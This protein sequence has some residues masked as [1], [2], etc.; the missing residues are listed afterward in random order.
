[1]EEWK[2]N[3]WRNSYWKKEEAKL[4]L[5]SSTDAYK[6]CDKNSEVAMNLRKGIQVFYREV[7]LI[8]S[9]V[10]VECVGVHKTFYIPIRKW[11][12]VSPVKKGYKL[13]PLEHKIIELPKPKRN[14]SIKK[15]T[16]DGVDIYIDRDKEIMYIS[17]NE[18][19]TAESQ[20]RLKDSFRSIKG[21]QIMAFDYINDIKFLN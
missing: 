14:K 8:N 9:H 19:M 18:K 11:N 4:E 21:Y 2:Y 7:I 17:M 5:A 3:W 1:M 13:S 15:K 6:D 10:W 20:Q 16:K 12:G